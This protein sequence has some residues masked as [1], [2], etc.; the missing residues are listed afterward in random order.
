MVFPDHPRDFWEQFSEGSI[1]TER[2]PSLPNA[3]HL[4]LL[5]IPT[6]PNFRMCKNRKK[7][8][9]TDYVTHGARTTAYE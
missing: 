3:G 6:V 2:D 8:F 1:N 7:I 4:P 9:K 5:P